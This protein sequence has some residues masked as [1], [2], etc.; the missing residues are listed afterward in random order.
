MRRLV[1]LLICIL[2]LALWGCSRDFSPAAPR[3]NPPARPL[4]TPEALLARSS[5]DFGWRLFTHVAGESG[6]Q[7]TLISPLSVT[8]ALAMAYNGAGGETESAMRTTLGFPESA[9]DEV[10]T[11]LLGL[12]DLL[13]HLDYGVKFQIANSIWYRQGLPVAADFIERNR[14]FYAASVQPLDFSAAGAPAVI[15]AWASKN[16][17]GRIPHVIDG[18]DPDIMLLL[19]NAIYFKGSWTTE[20]AP[21]E[22]RQEPFTRADG[23]AIPCRMMRQTATLGYFENDVMQAVDLPYGDGHFA[24]T[25]ILAKNGLSTLPLP[26]DAATWEAWHA[27]F[28]Q[29]NGTLYLPKFKFSGELMLNSH[30]K[31]LGMPVA[32]DDQRA[33]FSGITMA[34]R[35]F[36]SYVKH[37]SF[38]QVDE[39]GTEAAAVTVVGVGTTSIGEPTGFLMHV[40]RPFLVVIHD[41]HSK[42]ALFIGRIYQPEWK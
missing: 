31:A 36:I 32:F 29:Q 38:I 15:N 30:L 40:N 28:V 13:T 42:T 5:N 7:N 8:L 12:T 27:R 37:C 22:T 1:A 11:G 41:H 9:R 39:E 34:M 26:Q 20:F 33:D 25:V 16:T 23:S 18:I 24:M 14:T 4:T 21:T 3:E 17:N 19:L 6:E 35:L 2:L 10:N